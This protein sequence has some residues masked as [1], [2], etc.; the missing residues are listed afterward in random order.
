[1]PAHLG[2]GSSSRVIFT[3][4]LYRSSLQDKAM[5]NEIQ[6]M[7]KKVGSV[8]DAADA[9]RWVRDDRTFN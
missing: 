9:I 3:G 5:A 4:H 7:A 8:D 1:L 6:P 2:Y